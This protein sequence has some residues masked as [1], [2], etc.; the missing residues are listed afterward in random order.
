MSPDFEKYF[1]IQKSAVYISYCGNALSLCGA[2]LCLKVYVFTPCNFSTTLN[3]S[4]HILL[5]HFG[6]GLRCKGFQLVQKVVAFSSHDIDGLDKQ[7]LWRH[8][9]TTFDRKNEV[10]SRLCHCHSI[11]EIFM[12]EH[13]P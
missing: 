8:S 5:Y 12:P 4:Y 7:I 9:A 3:L 1:W 13:I 10:I 11:I 6:V 2:K